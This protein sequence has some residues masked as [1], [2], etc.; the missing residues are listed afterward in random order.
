VEKSAVVIFDQ[1]KELRRIVEQHRRENRK[2]GNLRTIA[3]LSGKGGVGKSNLSINLACALA[4]G[5]KKVVL[6]DADLGLA[7][8]DM[9]CGITAKYNLSHVIEGNKTLEE[10]LVKLTCNVW[11]LPGGSGVRE[12]ADLDEARLVDLID[13][14]SVLEDRAEILLID[15]GA[16]IHKG[17][18]AFAAAADTLILLTTPEPTSIRDAYSVLKA[19]KTSSEEGNKKDVAFVV[20]MANN[21]DE[22]LEVAKRLQTAA[23]QFLGFSIHYLGC[24]VKDHSVEY[25][26]RAR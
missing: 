4:E 24:I 8:I 7:N 18:L 23:S 22:G 12:L 15:T 11:I 5:G 25:A 10:V 9:L 14:M 26:V 2:T 3:I 17:V 16:G 19:L 6:L 1:A 13:S 20:N 21:E